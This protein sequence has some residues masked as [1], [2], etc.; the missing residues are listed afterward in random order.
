MRKRF[1]TALWIIAAIAS[2]YKYLPGQTSSGIAR[3]IQFGTVLPATCSPV[4]GDAFFLVNLSGPTGNAYFCIAVNTWSGGGTAYT[5]TFSG[6]TGLTVTAATHAQGTKVMGFAFDNATPANFITETANFPTVAANGDIVFAW[7]GSK[8]GY[9]IISALGGMGPGGP[10]GATGAT[11]PSGATGPTGPSGP[12]GATGPVGPAG[13]TGVT[14]PSGPTGATGATG[15]TGPAGAGGGGSVFTGS[16][17]TTPSFSATPTYS[18]ADINPTQS[19]VR[20]EAGVLTGN[21]TSVTFTNAKAGAKFDLVWVQDGTGGRTVTYG[22]TTLGTCNISPAA[23]AETIQLFEVKA[24]GSTVE[25][26]GCP[27]NEA[28]IVRYPATRVAPTQAGCTGG[29]CLWL[30]S[31]DN[32]PEFTL[33]GG[34]ANPFKMF[35][36]GVDANPVNGQVTVGT[37]LTS[38]STVVAQKFFGTA[39]PGSVATNLPG[40]FFTDTTNHNEYVCNAPSG[41]VAPACTS[42]STAGWLLV[43]GGGTGTGVV[44][45]SVVFPNYEPLIVPFGFSITTPITVANT[46]SP[47]TVVGKTLF[48]STAISPGNLVGKTFSIKLSGLYGTTGLPTLTFILTIGGVT[49]ATI[50]PTILTN[51]SNDG[52]ILN[53]IFTVASMTSVN[54]SGCFEDLGTSGSLIGGCSGATTAGLNFAVSQALDMTVTWSAASSSNTITAYVAQGM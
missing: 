32:E 8:T 24:D 7:T 40:D 22:G 5:Q 35:L 3:H 26:Y 25:G 52:W 45:T 13:A 6:V 9:V 31:T 2:V 11:G 16:T 42:V 20:V 28:A 23:N 54:G 38:G 18:L 47:T 12:T 10:T 30:D 27:T 17:A 41:T 33:A 43:N 21:V 39:A 14:G 44:A 4:T 29:G 46:V 50:A 1:I 15:A 19:P 49:I 53:Y 48:G 37:H 51:A 36:S 34:P